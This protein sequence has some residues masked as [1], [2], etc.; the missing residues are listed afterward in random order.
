MDDIFYL[1]PV[2][3]DTDSVCKV[4]QNV[5][6]ICV[7]NFRSS[8]TIQIYTGTQMINMT[9]M[10]LSEFYEADQEFIR[11]HQIASVACISHHILCARETLKVMMLLLD[12][13]GGWI[14]SDNDGFAPIYDKINLSS[15]VGA[16]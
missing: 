9:L 4:F 11:T 16:N 13:W 14:G 6:G 10:G 5:N 15:L 2:K 3:L 7:K 8:D 12:K 1:S